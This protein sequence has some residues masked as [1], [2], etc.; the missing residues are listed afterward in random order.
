VRVS[1]LAAVNKHRD[2][3]HIFVPSAPEVST[4]R[5][6]RKRR[7]D[8][9]PVEACATSLP[10]SRR[11]QIT[12]EKLWL[13]EAW[14]AFRW[15]LGENDLQV[16][17]YDAITGGCEMAFHPDRVNENQERNPPFPS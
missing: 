12:G 2:D 10:V 14:S 15:F 7:F 6:A 4:S 13:D 16:P 1:P 9:Q 11:N 3:P 17:L 5:E 8:Q